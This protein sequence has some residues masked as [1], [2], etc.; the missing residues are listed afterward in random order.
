MEDRKKLSKIILKAFYLMRLWG[1]VVPIHQK[2]KNRKNINVSYLTLNL[3]VKNHR[4]I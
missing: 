4:T 2:E 1:R 3:A